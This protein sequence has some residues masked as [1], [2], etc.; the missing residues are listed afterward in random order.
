MVLLCLENVK[1][2]F[3]TFRRGFLFLILILCGCEQLV[4]DRFL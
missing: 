4:A 3:L 2:L 1:A